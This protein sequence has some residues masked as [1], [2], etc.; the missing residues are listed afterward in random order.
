M[1][2]YL[3]TLQF[4]SF[5]L[6]EDIAIGISHGCILTSGS[7]KCWGDNSEGQLGYGDSFDRG[8]FSSEMGDY[9]PFV[10][11]GS[12]VNAISSNL[13]SRFSCAIL[14]SLD[15]KC[16]GDSASGRTEQETTLDIGD[17][18]GEMG[19][20]LPPI[21]FPNALKVR[22]METGIDHVGIISFQGFLYLWG[23]NGAGQLGLG[24]TSDIG[25]GSNDMG[26][27]LKP[28]NMGSGRSTFQFMGSQTHTCAILDNFRVKCWGGPISDGRLGYGDNV[29][30]G[31]SPNQMSDYLPY[32]NLGSEMN[33]V[34]LQAAYA[35]T[36]AIFSDDSMKCW[37]DN[38]VFKIFIILIF[39][40][41]LLIF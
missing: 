39:D 31:D 6:V 32:L 37:G 7:F 11:L 9:L 33:V 8:D 40:F 41:F 3:P 16:W 12:S 5:V 14:D 36:C 22:F 24:H 17:D 4:G 29:A 18:G 1:G 20:N 13:G 34:N 28:A 23:E 30:R 35:H 10:N 19:D 26:N 38:F 25:D 21:S 2:S 15:L 27:Y